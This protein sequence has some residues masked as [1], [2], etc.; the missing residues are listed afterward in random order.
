MQPAR[1]APDAAAPR[2]DASLVG[3][4]RAGDEG[5]LCELLSRHLGLLRRVA[6][7]HGSAGAEADDLVQE[8]ALEALL[9]LDHLERPESVAAWLVGILRRKALVS[10][11]RTRV[12]ARLLARQG[13]ALPEVLPRPAASPEVGS[14]LVRAAAVVDRLPANLGDAVYL[15]RIEG[16]KLTEV[17]VALSTSLST[18]KRW[19]DEAQARIG[20]AAARARVCSGL[21]NGRGAAR[22]R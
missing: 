16:M 15:R 20:L 7:K 8:V 18:T 9:S 5:A 14:D 21:V 22:R 10:H 17:A 1:D 13:D 11:R 3:A 4:A 6:R 2:S 19:L 12:R